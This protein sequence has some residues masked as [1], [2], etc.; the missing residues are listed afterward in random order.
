MSLALG[1]AGY[2]A[3]L[4]LSLGGAPNIRGSLV[5]QAMHEVNQYKVKII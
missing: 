2:A 5:S 1:G 4:R 3:K